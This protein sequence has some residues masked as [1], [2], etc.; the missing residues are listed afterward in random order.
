[1]PKRIKLRPLT[2]EE[3]IQLEKFSRSATESH[4]IVE[5]AKMILLTYQGVPVRQ[6]ANKL[7]RSVPAVYLRLRQFA[8]EGIAGLQDKS[9]KG[10]KPT[11]TEA[12]RGQMIA[13]ARTDPDKLGLPIGHWSLD[14]L[15][16]YLHNNDQIGV[17]R[18]QLARILQ[19]EGLRWYQEKTYFTERPDPQFVE[20]RGRS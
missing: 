8:E 18:A 15:V 11:Y 3:R 13:L 6:I 20:K 19:A 2:N 10:R 14:R 17:S 5:R 1:M 9:G 16:D 7:D 12:E 4:R